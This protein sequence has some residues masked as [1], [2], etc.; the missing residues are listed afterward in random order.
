[1]IVLGWNVSWIDY[2]Q[3]GGYYL[4]EHLLFYAEQEN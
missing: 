3:D 1:M 2:V 4:E